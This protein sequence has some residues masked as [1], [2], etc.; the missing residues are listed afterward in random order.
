[1]GTENQPE[2]KVH[3]LVTI[4]YWAV[5]V[6]IVYLIFKYLLN[7]LMPFF[8]AFLFAAVVRPIS[9]WLSR[10][11]RWKKN[12]AGEK[13][14]VRR[15]FRMN[16]NLAGVISVIVLFLILGGLLALVIIRL[17]DSIGSVIAAI[18]DVYYNNVAPGIASFLE[19]VEQLAARLD[20]S[21]L[22]VVQDSIPNLISSLG[23]AVTNFSTVALSWLTSFATR[24]PSFLL[25]TV[26]CLI[27]TVFIAVDFDTIKAFIKR[28]LPEKPLRVVVDVKD[29]F[30]DMVWQFLKSYFIIFCITS[31]EITVGLLII[32]VPNPLL[33]GILIAIFD[34]FPI[35]GSG[36]ILLPWAIITLI[37]GKVWRGLGLAILYAVVVIARQ[38]IEPKIVGK[39]V[40]LRPLVTLVCMYAGS[41]LFGG[42]G[43][44]G[45]PITAA[46]LVDL[47]NSGTIHLFKQ[48]EPS[49]PRE[50]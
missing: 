6:A 1:M 27:A 44:F 33:I 36:M 47:N 29:S 48:A 21:V 43:L 5:I 10:E 9:R 50:K 40:G 20:A 25:K 38:I 19:K 32:G 15:R 12:A 8:L 35:V 28:N 7:L 30:L 45:L 22:K 14:Q 2:K 46:I 13:V 24:L 31:A 41:R 34:A 37:T 4:A 11:Y 26:I 23:S 16:R 17:T 49:L 42:L 3:F 39:H 18:P